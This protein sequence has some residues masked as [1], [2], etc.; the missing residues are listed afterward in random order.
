MIVKER[1]MSVTALWKVL[2]T[3]AGERTSGGSD[4]PGVVTCYTNAT[5]NPI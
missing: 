4:V 1:Q 2:C 3:A 5:Q